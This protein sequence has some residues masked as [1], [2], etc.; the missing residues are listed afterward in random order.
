MNTKVLYSHGS[1]VFQPGC[2]S[3]VQSDLHLFSRD[4]LVYLRGRS[5]GRAPRQVS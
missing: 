3:S 5:L 2:I 4:V 1:V